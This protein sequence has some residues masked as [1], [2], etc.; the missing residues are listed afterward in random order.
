MPEG[1]DASNMT[2]V[3]VLLQH[4]AT[5]KH[6]GAF[7]CPCRVSVWELLDLCEGDKQWVIYHNSKRLT[8]QKV[9]V[10]HG[11]YF[12]CFEMVSGDASPSALTGGDD[13]RSS[14]KPLVGERAASTNQLVN[15]FGNPAHR[16]AASFQQKMADKKIYPFLNC[17]S[18]W[19]IYNEKIH[20]F[21]SKLYLKFRSFFIHVMF[22]S[23]RVVFLMNQDVFIPFGG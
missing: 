8:N 11:D 5:H 12:A 15:P 2:R 20:S 10:Q 13:R 23:C 17:S 1:H 3:V 14:C 21:Q 9:D 6:V 22:M 4:T 7:H 16:K 19:N 18:Q